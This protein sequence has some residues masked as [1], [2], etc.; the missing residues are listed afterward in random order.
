MSWFTN[1]FSDG[2]SKVID[3]VGNALDS[4]ITSDE[5]KLMIQKAVAD[6]MHKFELDMAT[7]ANKFES[8]ITARHA[9]DMKSDSWLSK[10]IRPVT[11]AITG[12]TIYMLVYLTVFMNLTKSQISVLEAWIPMLTGLFTTMVV[13][14]F[15]SRGLEKVAKMKQNS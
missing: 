8:E 11:L 4:L 2:A 1:L 14:Y 13:F 9:N 12:A 10:N 7:E 6:A 15:G 3:S 5:E